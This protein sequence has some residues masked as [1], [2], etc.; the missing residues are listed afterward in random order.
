MA[1][2]KDKD[3]TWAAAKKIAQAPEQDQVESNGYGLLFRKEQK[4]L[5]VS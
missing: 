3:V 5:K 4:R 2:L 1:K